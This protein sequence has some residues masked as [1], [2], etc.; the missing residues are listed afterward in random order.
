MNPNQTNTSSPDTT[1][2]LS[3]QLL[4]AVSLL[5]FLGWQVFA[6]ARQHLALVRMSEQQAVLVSQAAQT[7]SRIQ[8]MMTDLIRLSLSDAEAKAIVT[9]YRIT[10][11]PPRQPGPAEGTQVQPELPAPGQNFPAKA[12]SPDRNTGRK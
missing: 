4:I 3:T 1:S 2:A 7:E 11:N 12:I 10:Y 5:I 9:K 6:S 8:S